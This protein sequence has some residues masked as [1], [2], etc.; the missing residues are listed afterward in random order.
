MYDEYEGKMKKTVA[1]KCTFLS[2][3]VLGAFLYGLHF[4]DYAV[5]VTLCFFTLVSS[6]LLVTYAARTECFIG[7]SKRLLDN[8]FLNRAILAS[9]AI[10][11]AV[12][13]VPALGTMFHTVPLSA[14][15]LAASFAFS[16]IPILGTESSKLIFKDKKITPA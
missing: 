3:G 11:F 14:T 2:V 15:Q 13:Y 10:L 6:E 4:Y 8:R 1:Y 12:I 9:F 16:L 7:L 5:A